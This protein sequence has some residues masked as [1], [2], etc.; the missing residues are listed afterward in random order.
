MVTVKVSNPS[1]T[2]ALQIRLTLR[3]AKSGL[4]VLPV[5]YG[6]NYFSLLSGESRTI[7]IETRD[8]VADPQVTTGGWNIE[9]T[10][11]N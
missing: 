4:R 6:D 5:Y 11:L 1:K 10:S 2:P 9:S 3:H 8:A 7:R